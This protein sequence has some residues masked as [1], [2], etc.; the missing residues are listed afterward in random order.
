MSGIVHKKRQ[1]TAH[2]LKAL[3]LNLT[4]EQNTTRG[5]PLVVF[6]E[7]MSIQRYKLSVDLKHTPNN[8]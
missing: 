7:Q 1:P 8:I 4:V 6:S 3:F 5:R 2:E